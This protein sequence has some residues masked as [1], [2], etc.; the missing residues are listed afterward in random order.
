MKFLN[1]RYYVEVKDKP[2]RIHPIEKIILRLRDQP[3]SLRTQYQV[4]NKTQFREN[5]N[6]IRNDNDELEVKNYPKHKQPVNQQQPKFRAPSCPSWKHSIWLKSD[7][8]IYCQNCGM[9]NN[10]QKHQIDKEVLKQDHFSSTTLNY[11]GRKI[12]EIYYSMLN[13]NYKTTED[14][15][16]KIQQLKGKTK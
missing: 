16:N 13:T 7:Q 11:A 15:I 12:R 10:K 4:Q 1:G 14:M 6:V 3:K 5:Q 2:Y 8:E 9:I